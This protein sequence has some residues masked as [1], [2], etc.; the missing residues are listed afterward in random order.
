[1]CKKSILT[2]LVIVIGLWL[3]DSTYAVGLGAEATYS[4]DTSTIIRETTGFTSLDGTWSHDNGGDEWDGSAIGEGSP[5][6]VSVIDGYL[7]IQDTGDPRD[8]GFTDPGSNRK[9]TFAHDL[10]P[11]G[12]SDTFLN[13]GATFFF[14]ARLATD[15]PLDQLYPGGGAISDFPA[16][17][18]GYLIHNEGKGNLIIRQNSVGQ[19][20]F[21]LTT[22]EENGVASG[23]M[24]SFLNGSE[25]GTEV[26][27]GEGGI[28]N[29]IPLD[30]TVW[31]DF[32]ITIQADNSGVGTHKIDVYVDGGPAQTFSVTAGLDQLY[33]DINYV[34]LAVGATNQSGAFDVA[35]LQFAPG[36]IA[37]NPSNGATEV[38]P[39]VAFRWVPSESAS[40]YD[41]YLGTVFDDVNDANRTNPLGVLVAQGL[42]TNTFI[43]DDLLEYGQ[44]Y[45]WRIDKIRDTDPNNPEK[46]ELWSFTVRNYLVVDDFESYNDL[47]IDEEGARRIYLIWTDGYDNPSVNG[48]T[49]GYPEPD[50]ANDEHFVETE[51]VHWGNQSAPIFFN[52]TTA[53]YSEVTISTNELPVGGDWS[54]FSPERLSL[55]IHGDPNNPGTEQMYVKVNGTKATLDADLTLAEWQEQSIN[56]TNLGIDISNVATLSIGIEKTNATGGSGV[57]FVD[58]IRL[59]RPEVQP[60]LTVDE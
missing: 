6:G 19:M 18:D 52:N 4:L 13:D 34:A 54:E 5:G 60:P 15:G 42:E 56:L 28:M 53:S 2:V 7:R 38:V 10:G 20:G 44:T 8:F 12:A 48:S 14:R 9:I 32:W 39:D 58:D 16:Y 27:F 35:A 51:I 43:P 11:D 47:N 3:A 1:M 59:Y 26:D 37:N 29:L 40:A 49:M 55:W 31:H 17:G 21:A 45:Y 22:V 41:I 36:V 46:G 33:N 23:L 24:L 30:P 25:T 50:F 57:V